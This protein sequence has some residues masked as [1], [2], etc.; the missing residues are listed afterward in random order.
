[1]PTNRI[2]LITHIVIYVLPYI[3]YNS[4]LIEL[5]PDGFE[6]TFTSIIAPLGVIIVRLHDFI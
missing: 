1:M 4:I 6:G 3:L 5:T 2:A